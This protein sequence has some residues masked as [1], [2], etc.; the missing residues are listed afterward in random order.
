MDTYAITRP[1]PSALVAAVEQMR[2]AAALT[3]MQF[4]HPASLILFLRLRPVR[5][6]IIAR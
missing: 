6:W 3:G 4:P 1:A 5:M 2:L